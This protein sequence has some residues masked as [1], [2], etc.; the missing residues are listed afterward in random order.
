MPEMSN[1]KLRLTSLIT[2]FLSRLP[3]AM[4]CVIVFL[5]H[6]LLIKNDLYFLLDVSSF[7][8]DV[9]YEHNAR[10]AP[11]L[12]VSDSKLI[13]TKIGFFCFCRIINLLGSCLP[14]LCLRRMACLPLGRHSSGQHKADKYENIIKISARSSLVIILSMTATTN[15]TGTELFIFLL[16]TF[17]FCSEKCQLGGWEGKKDFSSATHNLKS[18]RSA[19][20]SDLHW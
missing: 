14:A 2:L 16:S 11:H 7:G 20:E 3:R 8:C 6:A 10:P 15:H 1:V 19:A 17:F 5:A 9:R 13:A 4:R 18:Q 12:S